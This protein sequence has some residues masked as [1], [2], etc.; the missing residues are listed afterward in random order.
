MVYESAT[1]EGIDETRACA[2]S[3]VFKGISIP[4]CTNTYALWGTEQEIENLGNKRTLV[5]ACTDGSTY[6]GSNSGAGFVFMHD[7]FIAKETSP[8]GASW[9]I[10][11]EDNFVAEMAA[12][13]RT[14]RSIPMNVDLIIHTDSKSCMQT[15]TKYRRQNS[16]YIGMECPARCHVRAIDRALRARET[17]GRS[18]TKIKHVRSHTG[19]RT[20]QAVGNAAAD[21]FAKKAVLDN[22]GNED[23]D[24]AQNDLP[25][26]VYQIAYRKAEEG[27]VSQEPDGTIRVET[28]IHA[29]IRKDIRKELLSR[30]DKEWASGD[31]PTRGQLMR[32]NPGDTHKVI[33]HAWKDGITSDKI[34]FLMQSLTQTHSS[35]LDN[36][37]KWGPIDC[38]AC[39]MN[40]PLTQTHLMDCPGSADITNQAELVMYNVLMLLDEDDSA[41]GQKVTYNVPAPDVRRKGQS[42]AAAF[43][44]SRTTAVPHRC[45]QS[46]HRPPTDTTTP[47][48]SV[49]NVLTM[50]TLATHQAHWWDHD[51]R[52]L[53]DREDQAKQP[54][55]P[56]H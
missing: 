10:Q 14:I 4:V 31:R 27:E 46:G 13:N 18:K 9:R 34:R 50:H 52:E 41:T 24:L 28:P 53:A 32:E 5:I 44:P 39:G 3:L 7:N 12:I 45:P 37:G 56:T 43:C 40:T 22:L 33:N 11:V 15:I 48:E 21:R 26:L 36:Q 49:E 6:T 54:C 38:P 2:T 8:T 23:I 17:F 42:L 16:N 20:R 30:R 51:R 19:N 47:L 25:Y 1:G 35:G 29:A 55:Q